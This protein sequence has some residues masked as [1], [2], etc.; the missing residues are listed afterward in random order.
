MTTP[1]ESPARLT[2]VTAIAA[3]VA[4]A[5]V[6][7]LLAVSVPAWGVANDSANHFYVGWLMANG[8]VIY[9]DIVEVNWPGTFLLHRALAALGADHDLAWRLLDLALIALA[10]GLV[11]LLVRPAGR[12][13]MVVG[14]VMVASGHLLGGPWNLGQRDHFVGVLVLASLLALRRGTGGALA[15]GLALGVA[16]AIKPFALVMPAA[17]LYAVA[18]PL[19]RRIVVM[20]VVGA[21]MAAV[22]L[23]AFGYLALV[24]GLQDFVSQQLYAMRYYA[25]IGRRPLLDAAIVMAIARSP[26]LPLAIAGAFPGPAAERQSRRDALV[27]LA[28]GAI[29]YAAQG[30]G[31]TYHSYPLLY[32]LAM[33]AALGT[34]R[35]LAARWTALRLLPAASLILLAS[36]C[37]AVMPRIVASPVPSQTPEMLADLAARLG[38]DDRVQPFDTF[39]AIDA[40]RRL[41]VRPA[42]RFLY[43]FMFFAGPTEPAGI[44]AQERLRA[45]FLAELGRAMPRVIVVTNQQWPDTRHGFERFDTW[46]ELLAFLDERYVLDVERATRFVWRYRVYLRREP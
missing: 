6:V 10:A 35:L 40:M 41:R 24:G 17:A 29:H 42:T 20:V 8:A 34:T 11:A 43:D 44:A 12:V 15:A 22:L 14:A 21:A 16:A 23:A 25:D 39:S 1:V 36:I 26:I 2:V 18:G 32:G 9:R 38:P 7:A 19:R 5:I 30:K 3:I 33:L 27:M 4:A 46:P 28:Y 13:A 31:L 45:E 37:A